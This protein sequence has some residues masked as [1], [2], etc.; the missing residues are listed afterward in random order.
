MSGSVIQAGYEAEEVPGTISPRD[1]SE[2]AL[3]PSGSSAQV[4]VDS[5]VDCAIYM[6]DLD[7]TVKSWNAG[8]QRF[9][10]Y[11]R[12]LVSGLITDVFEKP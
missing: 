4:L 7:S 11:S 8:A 2:T 9:K 1:K 12:P 3:E 6:L 10:G 5:V